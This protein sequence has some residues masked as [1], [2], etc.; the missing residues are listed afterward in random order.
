MDAFSAGFA[1]FSSVVHSCN[2]RN[3]RTPQ[4]YDPGVSGVVEELCALAARARVAV[5]IERFALAIAGKGGLCRIDGELVV[6]VDERL[7]RVEQAGVIGEALASIDLA[8]LGIEVPPALRAYVR[9]GH[10]EVKPLIR[11]RPLV[12]VR[13]RKPD[14]TDM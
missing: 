9:S 7:G 8:G 10:G 1:G 6:L 4:V 3:P 14:G 11:P 13:A 2:R 5:R 12:R